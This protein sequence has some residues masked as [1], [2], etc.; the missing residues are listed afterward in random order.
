MC[1]FCVKSTH[2]SQDGLKP[3]MWSRMTVGLLSSSAAVP[4]LHR[5]VQFCLALE[6]NPSVCA[7][8]VSTVLTEIHVNT[9]GHAHTYTQTSKKKS[10]KACWGKNKRIL[11]DCMSKGDFSKVAIRK[12]KA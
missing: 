11:L 2:I 8:Y 7:R 1:K 10:L 12:H 3:T 5:Y 9:H 6:I 4:S